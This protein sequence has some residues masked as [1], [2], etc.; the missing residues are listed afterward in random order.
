MVKSLVKGRTNVV[1]FRTLA[2]FF[3]KHPDSEGPL[4]ALYRHLSRHEW[5][6]PKDIKTHYR[7][8]D[9]VHNERVVFNVGGNK[10]RVV[11]AFRYGHSVAFIRF[12]GTHSEYDR[13]NVEKI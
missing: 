7:T 12:V 13:I 8:A 6:C 5:T 9:F 2:N 11:V 4:R 3:R 1:A 10:Y